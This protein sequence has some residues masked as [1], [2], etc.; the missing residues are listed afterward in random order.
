MLRQFLAN[1]NEPGLEE[2]SVANRDQGVV[3]VHVLQRQR[4]GFA[5]P[6]PSSIKKKYQYPCAFVADRHTR[7]SQLRRRGQE[8]LYL[9]GFV[10]VGLSRLRIERLNRWQRSGGPPHNEKNCATPKS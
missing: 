10:N 4:K 9:R 3:D 8:V 7:M 2:L 5:D 6:Y 1:R